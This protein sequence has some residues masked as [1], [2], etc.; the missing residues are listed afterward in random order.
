MNVDL[1]KRAVKETLKKSK[2]IIEV[3]KKSLVE[4]MPNERK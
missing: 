2:E 3:S 4:N 1:E